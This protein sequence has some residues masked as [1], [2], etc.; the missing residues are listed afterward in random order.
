MDAIDL[1][2]Y[3]TRQSWAWLNMTVEG[4]TDEMANWQPPGVANSIAA[5]SRP[6]TPAVN[7]R[8]TSE[9]CRRPVA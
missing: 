5:T 7:A 2:R 3:Q 4:I 8:R 1:I 6:P 9:R